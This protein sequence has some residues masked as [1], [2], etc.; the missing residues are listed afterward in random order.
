M[1]LAEALRQVRT[2]VLRPGATPAEWTAASIVAPACSPGVRIEQAAPPGEPFL[3][4][5]FVR[6][7]SPWYSISLQ[8][9]G[10]VGLTASAGS[11]LVALASLVVEWWGERPATDFLNAARQTPAFSWLRN[12]SD[13]L[14]GS[15]RFA[16]GFNR[17]DFCRQLARQGFTH[18]TINGLGVGRPFESGP[19]GDVYHWFYDYS[20]DLDQFVDST[21][22]Q[23]YYPAD[24]LSANLV[25]LKE[26]AALAKRYGLTP[27]LHIN[28]PRSMP[29]EF[30]H[31][32]GFLRGARVDHPR[33]TLRPRYT[34][35]MAHPAVQQH[36][37]ELMRALMKE[38]PEIGFIHVWTN[39]SGSGFEFVS[40]LYAGRNGGP[41]LI[42]EWK[43]EEEIARKAGENVLT[44]YRLL[45][46]EGRAVNPEFRLVCDLGPFSTEIKHI[47]QGLGDGIDA[48]EFAFFEK[49][50]S[51]DEKEALTRSG[52]VVHQKLDLTDNTLPGLPFPRLVYDRLVQIRDDGAKA[53]LTGSSPGSLA[54][55]DINGEVIRAVQLCPQDS[56]EHTLMRA[57]VRW[58][59]E[60]FANSLM[61]IWNLSDTAVRSFPAGVP[62]STFAFPW[63]RLWIRPFVPDVD[64]IPEE[65]RS[66][67]ERFL[68]ATFNN[69]ARID[70][71]SDMLWNFLTVRQAGEKKRQIDELVLRLLATA[72][73][74]CREALGNLSSD[75]PHADV[76]RDLLD[77]L[78]AA[79][80]FYTTM[81]NTM[82]WTESVHGYCEATTSGEKQQYRDLCRGM[83]E[84]ELGNA[85]ELLL[86]WLESQSKFTPISQGGES[87]HIYGKN[88]GDHLERKIALMERHRDDEPMIDPDYM[89]RFPTCLQHE[90]AKGKTS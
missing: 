47:V 39:D 18:V 3:T 11:L 80:C 51:A 34:L 60:K 12:L 89:W 82:A 23:G 66:Y 58:A 13:Y 25:F 85:R 78:R 17:D 90:P 26:T 31:R 19:P 4:L 43:S 77:R 72:I 46:D 2:I 10:K 67:Y 73:G 87:L 57:A 38:V 84:S 5:T 22:L 88:F 49:N 16:E 1:T 32:Y 37:R 74:L 62:M 86:L 35:A 28:S 8:D 68:L 48:G 33:E 40:S 79:W 6:D 30:W 45:R 56:L 44:Y 15:L 83:V 65:E 24:Y 53:V 76:F 52:A 9:A 36:Y 70:L 7:S 29:E 55:Y 41:Y 14:V 21:L 64:A 42:R 75:P 69:P 50:V 81:R 61:E 59:G 71:N 54:P 63:F 20:P 27:G